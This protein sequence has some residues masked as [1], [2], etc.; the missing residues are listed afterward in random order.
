M[1]NHESITADHLARVRRLKVL[2]WVCGILLVPSLLAFFINVEMAV[3]A[4]APAARFFFHLIPPAVIKWFFPLA[5]RDLST[6]TTC[7]PVLLLIFPLVQAIRILRR[8]ENDPAFL[9]NLAAI[10][11][12]DRFGFF[13]VMFGLV[14]TLW[15]MLIGISA[16]G[17]ES[18]AGVIPSA[19]SIPIAVRRLLEGTATAIWSSLVGIIGAFFATRPISWLFRWAAVLSREEADQTLSET[20]GQLTRDLKGLSAASRTFTDRLKPETFDGFLNALQSID[21]NSQAMEGHFDRIHQCLLLMVREHEKT[22]TL[23]ARL[24]VLEAAMRQTGD[25]LAGQL[26]NLQGGQ[27]SG[28]EALQTLST[29]LQTRH[30][31][32]IAQLETLVTTLR[33]SADAGRLDRDQLHRALG[34]YLSAKADLK[35]GS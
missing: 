20:M 23:L 15:G 11:Y 1:P 6:V 25:H 31:A 3:H 32:T 29:D 24:D 9:H 26:H 30:A 7:V 10:P 28:I 19:E 16:S 33:A 21:R 18:L 34:V 14:G 22:N 13:L 8:D 27:Q 12:P 5:T 4:V 35:T 17:V 2:A